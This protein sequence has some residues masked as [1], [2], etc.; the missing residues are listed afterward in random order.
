VRYW[1]A[2]GLKVETEITSPDEVRRVEY[3]IRASW[4]Q[5][6]MER[7]SY[8]YMALCLLGLRSLPARWL[9]PV[10]TGRPGFP[11]FVPGSFGGGRPRLRYLRFFEEGVAACAA[12]S[13]D[14][15]RR[16]AG[17]SLPEAFRRRGGG[18][19]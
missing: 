16:G 7:G 1:D 11:A 3:G 18:L 13:A 12:A 2:H 9:F 19:A 17:S 6:H 14:V 8:L 15:L 5:W 10:Y 4:L